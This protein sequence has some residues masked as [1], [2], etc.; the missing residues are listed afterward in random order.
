MILIIF[1]HFLISFQMHSLIFPTF[2]MLC[3]CDLKFIKYSLFCSYT[4]G[5][6]A[7]LQSGSLVTDIT[8]LKEANSVSLFQELSTSTNS[9]Y[10]EG[11]LCPL[12]SDA[13][14]R[15]SFELERLL[16]RLLSNSL[17]IHM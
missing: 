7:I 5:Y 15:V 3:L 6:V 8:P 17:R 16:C 13:L 1:S 9:R 10:K 11:I 2:P 4:L 14:E 12:P